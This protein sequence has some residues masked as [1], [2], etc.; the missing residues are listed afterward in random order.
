MLCMLWGGENSLDAAI[1]LLS[2]PL[3]WLVMYGAVVV[4]L[5]FLWVLPRGVTFVLQARASREV[6]ALRRAQG[7]LVRE[8]GEGVKPAKDRAAKTKAKPKPRRKA[9]AP[10]ATSADVLAR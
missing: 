2:S 6:A 10:R 5:S 7:R 1:E 9:G 3:S 8:W 4:A